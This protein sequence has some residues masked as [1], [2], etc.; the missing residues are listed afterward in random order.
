MSNQDS[1]MGI[2]TSALEN[3]CSCLLLY[4]GSNQQSHLSFAL[5]GSPAYTHVDLKFFNKGDALVIIKSQIPLGIS[6]G[7]K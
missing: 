5:L 4:R 1:L 3:S 6:L 7:G 2:L